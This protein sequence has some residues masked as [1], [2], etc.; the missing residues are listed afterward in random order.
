MGTL[1]V[2]A[3]GRGSRLFPPVAELLFVAAEGQADLSP[4]QVVARRLVALAR[5]PM[6]RRQ[7][8]LGSGLDAPGLFGR[9]LWLFREGMR[10]EC[11][12]R[13]GLADFYWR[14]S[15]QALGALVDRPRA[16]EEVL[17]SPGGA[18]AG[19]EEGVPDTDAWL[20]AVVDELFIDTHCAFFNGRIR[21]PGVRS[22]SD[23]AFD[24]A[25][26]I[27]S[28][29]TWGPT[30]PEPLDR[31][32]L[33]IPPGELLLE[34][35]R[36][37]RQWDQATAAALRLWHLFPDRVDFLDRVVDVEFQRTTQGLMNSRYYAV[38]DLA[39]AAVLKEGI[40]RLQAFCREFPHVLSAFAALGSLY[41]IRAAKLAK[42]GT[43]S[44][45]LVEARRALDH[46]PGRE[47]IQATFNQ[48]D[49]LLRGVVQEGRA[50]SKEMGR[51]IGAE[52]TTEGRRLCIEAGKGYQPFRAYTESAEP[53]ETARA[54]AAAGN[55]DV[56]RRMGLLPPPDRFEDR[57]QALV[58]AVMEFLPSQ[59]ADGAAARRARAALAER[60]AMLGSS[61][62]E[63][64]G[65]SGAANLPGSRAAERKGQ[66]PDQPGPTLPDPAGEPPT[67]PSPAAGRRQADEPFDFWLFS[68]RGAWL[69][70]HAMAAAIL[71][72]LGIGMAVQRTWNDRARNDAYVRVLRAVDS[73]D[74]LGIIRGIEAFLAHSPLWHRDPREDRLRELYDEAMV[75]WFAGREAPE[76]AEAREHVQRYRRLTAG[77]RS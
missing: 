21:G 9:I 52:L 19:V 57:A 11:T 2:R 28:W 34:R 60:E 25:E 47:G 70:A 17:R 56:W 37:V 40:K 51:Q 46:A 26:A 50:V 7:R 18:A 14:Q 42:G 22:P 77:A 73:R 48:I 69:K 59:P 1:C 15:Q 31:V 33:L 49:E 74:Y 72:A 66:G 16:W 41:H 38:A 35:A 39:D 63:S 45:A 53:G 10:S 44:E 43:V 32:S 27:E 29:L 58:T 23:R 75:R 13:W 3:G 67:L 4:R 36:A 5:R 12:G 76:D 55:H 8:V 62:P 24:H 71:L 54:L 65:R 30:S 64:V 68:P 6:T 20:R 61:D